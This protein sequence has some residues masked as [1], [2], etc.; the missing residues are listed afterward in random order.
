MGPNLKMMVGENINNYRIVSFEGE[1]DRAGLAE[2]R[3]DLEICVNSFDNKFLIFDFS[4]LKFINS[5]GIGYLMEV[6][7]HL[8]QRDKQL[9][10][11]GLADHVADVFEAIGISQVMPIYKDLDSFLNEHKS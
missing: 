4:L 8:V 9:V 11:L 2:V 5:E 10:V 1:M 7:A 6:H 3:S